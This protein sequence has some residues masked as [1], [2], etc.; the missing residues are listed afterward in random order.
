MCC[1]YFFFHFFSQGRD[2]FSIPVTGRSPE[3]KIAMGQRKIEFAVKTEV[4]KYCT[5]Q[6]PATGQEECVLPQFGKF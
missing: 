2:K 5:V 6:T 4:G 3:S 1:K